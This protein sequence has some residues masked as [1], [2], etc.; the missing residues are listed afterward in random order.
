MKISELKKYIRE[1]ILAELGE[2]IAYKVTGG[3]GETAIQSFPD[4]TSANEF[5]QKNP[6]VSSIE[7]LEEKRR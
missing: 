6:N 4:S 3:T 5:K 1:T 2:N 7:K